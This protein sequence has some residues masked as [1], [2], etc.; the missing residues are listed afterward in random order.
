MFRVLERLLIELDVGECGLFESERE[1][2]KICMAEL[3]VALLEFEV[4]L[5]NIA[6]F[7]RREVFLLSQIM[8][9]S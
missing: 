9:P 1:R 8:K 3:L 5:R 6:V 2:E 7:L 4:I